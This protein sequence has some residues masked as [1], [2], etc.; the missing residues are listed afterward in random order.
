MWQLKIPTK[1][2]IF[3]WQT[4]MNALLT[5]QNIK[6]KG[7]NIADFCPPCE[8]V[9]ENLPHALLHYEH[10]KQTWACW[11]NYPVNLSLEA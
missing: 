9:L 7:V 2:G 8:K 4:C 1:I 5:M 10:A 6:L 3:A 11:H